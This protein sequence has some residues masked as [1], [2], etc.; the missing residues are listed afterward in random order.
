MG[1]IGDKGK[2]AFPRIFKGRRECTGR[3]LDPLCRPRS[4]FASQADSQ[5]SGRQEEKKTLPGTPAGVSEFMHV[6]VV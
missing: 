4:L 2:F 6:A 3:V 1:T 5:A